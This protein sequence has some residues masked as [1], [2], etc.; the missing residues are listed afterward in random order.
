MG[1]PV[2]Y[3][4]SMSIGIHTG[5]DED[6]P[7]IA[8]VLNEPMKFRC[9][10]VDEVGNRGLRFMTHLALKHRLGF[11]L[12]RELPEHGQIMVFCNAHPFGRQVRWARV[13]HGATVEEMVEWNLKGEMKLE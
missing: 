7:D 10:A 6:F 8:V 3:D 4:G 5:D 13:P 1:P 11:P 12:D 9:Y 2:W